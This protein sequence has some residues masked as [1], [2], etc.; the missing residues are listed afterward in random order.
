RHIYPAALFPAFQAFFCQLYAFGA[1]FHIPWERL[2]FKHMLE[3]TLPLYLKGIVVIFLLRHFGPTVEEVYRLRNVGTP[4]R[5][6]RIA[7]MLD[8]AF[9]QPRYCRTFGAIYLQ[10]QQVVP[11]HP[12]RPGRIEMRNDIPF[13]L[14]SSI[15]RIIG[16]AFVGLTLLINPFFDM[17]RAKTGHCLHFAKNIVQYIA[18]MAQHVHDDPSVI[19]LAVVPGRSLRGNG[20]PFKYP[21]AEFSPYGKDLSEKA[22]FDQA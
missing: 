15:C 11:S 16:G 2:I 21:V 20:I 22:I 14:E 6:R 7:I 5:L 12:Y 3:E 17:G 8:I 10:G 18:P 1:F 4:Y 9:S 13:Q 19:F